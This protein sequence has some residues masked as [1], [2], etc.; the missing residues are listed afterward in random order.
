MNSDA[1]GQNIALKG[2]VPVR[3][4]G[5]VVKGQS[6]FAGPSGTATTIIE[7]GA[8]I[9]GVALESNTST[10]EKLVECILKV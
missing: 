8:M 10:S 5:A 2:R 9:V 1:A 4:I 6:L 7:N 3:V